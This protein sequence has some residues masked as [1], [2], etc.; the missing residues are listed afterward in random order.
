[1]IND[2]LPDPELNCLLC[3]ARLVDGVC[4]NGCNIIVDEVENG[5]N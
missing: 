4:P 5:K 2:S 3:G 1:M